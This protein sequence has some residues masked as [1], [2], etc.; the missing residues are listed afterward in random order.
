MSDASSTPLRTKLIVL[1]LCLLVFGMAFRYIHH[2]NKRL[3]TDTA[4]FGGDVWEYQSLAVNLIR[5]HGYQAGG[6]EEFSVYRFDPDRKRNRYDSMHY[7]PHG[8]TPRTFYENFLTVK[9]YSFYRTPGYPFFLATVYCLFGIHPAAVYIAQMVLLALTA[10]LLVW[11]S[12]YYWGNI[13]LLSGV[14]ASYGYLRYFLPSPMEIMT[15]CVILSSLAVWVVV[16]IFWESKPNPFRSFVLGA[17]SAV[18]LLIKGSNI[19]IPF[20]FLLFLILQFKRVNRPLVLGSLYCLGCVL[21]LLPWSA[22][23]TVK[24]G[25]LIVLSTQT[26]I[27]LD[28]NNED[29]L[30]DGDWHATWRKEK[31][32]DPSYF[33]NRVNDKKG[34][35]FSVVSHFL[36]QNIKKVPRMWL[37]KIRLGFPPRWRVIGTFVGMTCY[38]LFVMWRWKSRERVPQFP[39][40]YLLN[41]FMITIIF[42]GNQRITQPFMPFFLVPGS[43]ITVYCGYRVMQW[44]RLIPARQAQSTGVPISRP[45]GPLTD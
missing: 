19:L 27:F 38:Y 41:I 45:P 37:L 8:G 42:Y 43:Y 33:Y 22:Y 3:I 40:I 39:L 34:S 31:S 21:T 18:L 23:A 24:N 12:F 7:P 16:L 6:I 26:T 36:R 20:F 13:G 4:W 17:A 5:G 9:K 14:L 10:A 30:K 35:S 28:S 29:T 1:F 2:K 44:L 15:E 32:G 25:S 11:I